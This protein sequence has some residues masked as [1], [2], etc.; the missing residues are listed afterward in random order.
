MQPRTLDAILSEL[1]PIYEPQVSSIRTRQGLIPGQIKEEEKGLQAQQGQAFDEI[2]GGARRR[3]LG[4]SGIPLG[5]QAKYTATNFL[6]A[7]AKLRQTGREQAMSLEDAILGINER[8]QTAAMGM[9]QYEQ[10][11]YDQYQEQLRREEEARRLQAEAQRAAAAQRGSFPNAFGD[12]TNP[13]GSNLPA[14]MTEKRNALGAFEGFAFTANGKPV[15]AA[16]YAA[17]NKLPLGDLLYQMG[18]SGDQTAQQAYNWVKSIQGTD[19]FNSGRWKQ[20]PAFQRFSS[21][22]WGL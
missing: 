14:G 2:L 3:G 9:R 17:V 20:T 22:F 4:F 13:A 16:T 18:S 12:P 15:S 1:S 19:L 6:P 5:E 21:L 7:M 11:R 8:K 10:Q